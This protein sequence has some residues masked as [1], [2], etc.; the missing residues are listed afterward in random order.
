MVI[1]LNIIFTYC[2]KISFLP[3]GDFISGVIPKAVCKRFSLVAFHLQIL[4]NVLV[5]VRVLRLVHAESFHFNLMHRRV[6]CNSCDYG[7][8][9]GAAL[10]KPHDTSSYN[11]KEALG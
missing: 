3:L 8:T 4:E 11:H 2:S 10:L 6:V 1:L 5:L 7:K 9:D